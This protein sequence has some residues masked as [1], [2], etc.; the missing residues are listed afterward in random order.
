MIK[1]LLRIATII[2]AIALMA[3]PVSAQVTLN[4]NATA[5]NG[6]SS[7]WGIFF[8]LS[9]AGSAITVTGMTTASTALAGGM[10]TI[11]VFSRIGTSLGGGLGGG[12]GSSPAGWT[13]LGM[14]SVTQGAVSSDISLPFALPPINI[15]DGQTVG[16]ALVFTGAGPRYFGTGSPPIQQFTDGTLTLATGDARTVPF[17]TTGS[18]FSSRGLTGSIT[19]IAVPEPSSIAL[20]SLAGAGLALLQHRRGRKRV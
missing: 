14:V 17:T 7:G 1:S 18:Y 19:Y 6:G 2:A 13:S 3:E 11:E 10:F 9:A 20:V 16:L 8:D 5:N 15:A 4:A 12:P